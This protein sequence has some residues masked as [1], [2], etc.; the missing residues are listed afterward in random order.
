MVY[1]IIKIYFIV[2]TGSIHE[3]GPNINTDVNN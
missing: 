3:L 2:V 1:F